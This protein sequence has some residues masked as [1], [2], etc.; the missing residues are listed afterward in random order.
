[1]GDQ[2]KKD[3][4]ARRPEAQKAGDP[5]SVITVSLWVAWL[6]NPLLHDYDC[7]YQLHRNTN[8]VAWENQYCG[9]ECS[10]WKL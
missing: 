8:G 9:K 3:T 5:V 10:L 4:L 2:K 7:W 6:L 1:M